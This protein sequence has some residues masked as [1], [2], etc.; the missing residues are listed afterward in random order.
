MIKNA[1][2]VGVGFALGYAKALNDNQEVKL[3]LNTIRNDQELKD[4]LKDLADSLKKVR[5]P[6]PVDSE[7]VV[8]PTP[9]DIP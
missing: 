3:L 2:L 9:P 8:E 1:L 7:P 5:D 6:K 4:A